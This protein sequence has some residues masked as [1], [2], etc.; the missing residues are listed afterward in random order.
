MKTLL[1]VW[2]INKDIN[3]LLWLC[4]RMLARNRF[5]THALRALVDTHL[6]YCNNARAA[7]PLIDLLIDLLPAEIKIM[8][9]R[10]FV[11]LATRKY[12]CAADAFEMLAVR[13]N[14]YPVILNNWAWSLACAKQYE[15]AEKIL[16]ESLLKSPD[17]AAA[18]DSM[19]FVCFNTGRLTEA[20]KYYEKAV[21][22]EPDDVIA[23]NHLAEVHAKRHLW[24]KVGDTLL[25][26]KRTELK[27]VADN[28]DQLKIFD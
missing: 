4:S 20:Q 6:N 8:E 13:T 15:E 16:E 7:E 23:W 24:E 9:Y 3:N 10:G 2:S 5:D 12:D 18:L 19:G 21:Q 28:P 27:V 25:Q 11:Y 22:A 17:D 14:R 26:A 1:Q